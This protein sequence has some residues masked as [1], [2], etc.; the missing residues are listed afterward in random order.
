MRTVS[1]IGSAAQRLFRGSAPAPVAAVRSLNGPRRALVTDSLGEKRHE[2]AKLDQ[3]DG[4][5]CGSAVLVALATWA[6]SAALETL[7]VRGTTASGMVEG[8]AARYDALQKEVH[9]QTNRLWPRMLGTTPWG[10]ARWLRRNAPGVGR[11]RMRFVDDTSAADV[12]EIVRRV[13]AALGA[14]R[15]VP[16]LVGSLVPRHYCLALRISDDGTWRVYEPSS[17]SVR[18]LDP[19]AIRERRLA[20]VLGFDRL[21]TVF[22]PR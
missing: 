5:T 1:A 7:E 9:R 22:L 19:A 8:F 14:R 17:G 6:D 21:H 2:G 13:E 12:D 15:P 16:L 10:F 18:P 4:T 3:A 20:P 11:Y